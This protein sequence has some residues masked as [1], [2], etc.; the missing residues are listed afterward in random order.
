MYA[1]DR[2]PDPAAWVPMAQQEASPEIWR[3]LYLV[4]DCGLEPE[5]ALA[6]VR[7]RIHEVDRDLALTDVSSMGRR[8]QD[9]L[10][11]QRFSSSVILT[12]GLAELAIAVLGVFGVTAYLATLRSHEFGIRVAV[13]ARPVDISHLVLRESSRQV[14]IGI[15]AGLLGA[16][17][18]TRVLSGLLYGVAPTDPL[19]FAAVTGLLAV[20]ALAACLIP[21]RRAAKVDPIL[22]LRSE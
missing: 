7:E 9:S 1:L 17:G 14:A 8:L 21:A 19:T 10:W 15:A 6:G 3:N 20:V 18:L 13:G 2:A 16:F 4:A 5:H 11:R 22:A 12:F